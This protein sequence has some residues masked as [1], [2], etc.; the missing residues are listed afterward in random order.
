MGYHPETMVCRFPPYPSG[1]RRIVKRH[2]DGGV[3]RRGPWLS[4][5]LYAL[6]PWIGFD[7]WHI[8][9]ERPAP[10][11]RTDDSCGWFDR[12]PGEYADAVAYLLN[13]QSFMHDLR[14]ILA[15]REPMPYPFYEGI[16]ERHMTGL[17]LPAGEA[18]AFTVMISRELE[19]RR[20]WNGQNGKA[21]AHSAGWRRM[22]MRRRPVSDE[23]ESLALNST[24]N[25]SHVDDPEGA[26]RLI[27]AALNR[28]FRPWWKHPRWHVHHWQVNFDL[29][30]NLK[31][32]F[33]PCA[34]CR[35]GLG[36]GYCPINNGQGLHHSECLGRA[37]GGDMPAMA[38]PMTGGDAAA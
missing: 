10:G 7:I 9:P 25:L 38:R 29:V 15:R 22:F 13:D 1:G 36:F 16:S 2:A 14:L 35:R 19:L 32:M 6:K 4:E 5:A 3:E 37:A 24:D 34:T 8:D 33:Q 11:Q 30:R 20:W 17:R 31:R 23:A 18:L 27:A 21:G 12:R 26:V 28:K